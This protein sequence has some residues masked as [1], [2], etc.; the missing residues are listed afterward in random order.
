MSDYLIHKAVDFAKVKA[1]FRKATPTLDAVYK[2]GYWLQRKYDGCMVILDPRKALPMSRTGKE[3][4]SCIGHMRTARELN[5]VIIAEAWV[6]G[7]DFARISGEFRRGEVS[8]NLHIVV[9]DLIPVEDFDTCCD[10]SYE[11]RV[12]PF[13]R[14]INTEFGAR[15]LFAWTMRQYEGDPQALVNDLMDVHPVGYDGMILRDPNGGWIAGD[16]GTRGEIIKVKRELSYDLEVTAV[17]TGVGG[18]TG[19]PVYTITVDFKGKPLGVGSGMPH[20]LEDVP[21]V[22]DI[23][24]VVAM[25]YSSDGLLR[26]PRF[27]GVRVDKGKPDA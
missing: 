26:E 22:G 5:R 9:H 1:A 10:L 11:E 3:Y 7:W 12:E 21:K 25:D 6:P 19:R 15:T 18:K 4:T 14:R 20:K 2:S 8:N 24:E 13:I 27:K 23:V 16:S 17:H